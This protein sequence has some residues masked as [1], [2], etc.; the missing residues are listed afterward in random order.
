[1]IDKLH[2]R[3]HESKDNIVRFLRDIILIPGTCGKEK[4]VICRVKK[5]METLS[6]DDVY[7]SKMGS[8]IGRIGNG[9][10]KIFYDCHVDTV[11]PGDLKAWKIDPYRG[12]YEN[13]I[14]YGLGACDTKAS[15][16]TMVYGGA[17]MKEMSLYGDFTLFVAA[18]VMEE[19][20][21]GEADRFIFDHK[22]TGQIPDCVVIGEPSSL[23][24]SRGN[25]GR[26]EIA[27]TVRGKSAHASSP[28]LGEN[29]IYKMAP[30]IS[31]LEHLNDILP[32]HPVMGKSVLAVTEITSKSSSRNAVP[33]ECSVFIDRRLVPGETL[34][35]VLTSIKKLP[36][37]ENAFSNIEVYRGQSYTGIEIEKEKFFP[38]WIM[39]ENHPLVTD[40]SRAYKKILGRTPDIF[41]WDFCTNGNYTA[42]I[43][44]IPTIGFG[45]GEERYAHTTEEQ[46]P[47]SH[48]L[49]ATIFYAGFPLYFTGRDL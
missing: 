49:D 35:D 37:F 31:E 8:V 13:D 47:V 32:V 10:K 29:A 26:V 27:I 42:G 11:G 19:D 39:E 14:V 33:A 40:A 23:R 17:L 12:A 22:E 9:K 5:E 3:V 25:R 41:T 15:V 46:V 1:M 7:V 16:A 43:A 44:G 30:L 45:P 6:Y 34:E 28:S 20:C 36:S 38:P 4:D 18:S 48:L 2:K 21:E 24:I